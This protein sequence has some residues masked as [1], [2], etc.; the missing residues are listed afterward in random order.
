PGKPAEAEFEIRLEEGATL[1]PPLEVTSVNGHILENA[2]GRTTT[3]QSV[4]IATQPAKVRARYYEGDTESASRTVI[5][6]RRA[7][8]E[9]GGVS[10]APAK[11]ARDQP[12]HIRDHAI[13]IQR[14]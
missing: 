6:L 7:G 10:F 14:R 9:K 12:L 1:K 5:T 4:R 3:T 8:E 2:T 11:V 13:T